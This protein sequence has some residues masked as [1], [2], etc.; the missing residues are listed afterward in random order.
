MDRVF[1]NRH[2]T[3]YVGR[4]VGRQ[5]ETLTCT[6]KQTVPPVCG[7]CVVRRFV[8]PVNPPQREGR[9]EGRRTEGGDRFFLLENERER[10]GEKRR[11][12]ERRRDAK[13]SNVSTSRS[14]V[15]S[16]PPPPL[17]FFSFFF[18]FGFEIRARAQVSAERG[19]EDDGAGG[20]RLPFVSSKNPKDARQQTRPD[21]IIN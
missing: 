13:L 15:P 21:K 12:E 6:Q 4:Q 16:S 10:R 2:L 14:R 19:G 5:V 18:P 9:R 20:C 7:D 8:R 3:Y 1:I 11:E 17:L